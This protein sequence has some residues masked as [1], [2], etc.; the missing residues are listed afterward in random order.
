[1]SLVAELIAR[2]KPGGGAD[3]FA[4]VEGATEFAQIDS[5]PTAM[6]AAYVMTLREAS[7][8][9]SRATGRVLQRLV[10][11][12]AVVIITS[13]LSDVP[14]SAVSSDIE[15]LKDWVRSRLIGFETPSSDDPIEHV[16]GELLKTKN[17]TVWFEDVFGAAG[18]LTENT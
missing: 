2:L 16:S 6:P 5:V 9:N 1:M 14:G 18:Y 3:A 15:D 17:G 8:E 11:D 13:N 12:I 7:D 10:S 4:I